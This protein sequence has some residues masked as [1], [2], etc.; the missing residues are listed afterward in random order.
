MESIIWSAIAVSF[1]LGMLTKA[2]PRVPGTLVG[3]AWG[4]SALTV[5]GVLLAKDA[6]DAGIEL[7]G[8]GL[9]ATL[10]AFITGLVL[11]DLV[12]DWKRALAA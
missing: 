5:T 1:V 4:A 11:V 12:T 9:V 7:F 10:P 6:S 8:I 2:L 3:S